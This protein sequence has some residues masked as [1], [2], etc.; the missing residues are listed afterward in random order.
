MFGGITT[1]M[2][3]KL[4]SIPVHHRWIRR[5]AILPEQPAVSRLRRRDRATLR[6]SP[7]TRLPGLWPPVR[8]AK[9]LGL[10][11]PGLQSVRAV[12]VI[13]TTHVPETRFPGLWPP[14]HRARGVGLRLPGLQS[15]PPAKAKVSGPDGLGPQLHPRDR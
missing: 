7:E 15:L 12:L 10:R 2:P 14:V 1:G 11:L 13:F 6:N 5:L 8:I 4:G 9:A 3:F